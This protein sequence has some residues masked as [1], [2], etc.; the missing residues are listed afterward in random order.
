MEDQR[1]ILRDEKPF[2]YREL[3]DSKIQI[4]YNGKLIMTI[5]G[6]DTRRFLNVLDRNDDYEI[7]LFLAK[8]TGQ[9]KHGNERN[10][11]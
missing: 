8:I 1:N 2:G 3:K 11:K 4:T 6:K 7:Q 5:R 9:F 10:S